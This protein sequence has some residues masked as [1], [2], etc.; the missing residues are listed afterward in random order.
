MTGNYSDTNGTVIDEITL[1]YVT[2]VAD[3]KTKL[4]GQPDPEFTYQVTDGSLL[5]GDAF[6]G[7]LTR[8]LG[9]NI[10]TYAILQGTLSLPEYYEMTYVVSMLTITG[11]RYLY[12][13]MLRNAP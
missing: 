5:S 9:N 12:P 1:R 6:S 4:Y 10:G 7:A 13:L 8:Q 3:S 2:V 11:Y